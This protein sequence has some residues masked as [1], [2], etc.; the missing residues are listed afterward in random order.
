MKNHNQNQNRTDQNR[1]YL[2]GTFQ[3]HR[4]RLW[5]RYNDFGFR[6]EAPPRLLSNASCKAD[7]MDGSS[8]VFWRLDNI[9]SVCSRKTAKIRVSEEI[10]RFLFPD[11]NLFHQGRLIRHFDAWKTARSFGKNL[12]PFSRRRCSAHSSNL[13]SVWIWKRFD[14][15]HVWVK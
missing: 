7:A 9:C 11:R 4:F 12:F 10:A 5:K 15:F 2:R 13:Y 3:Q 8:C 14:K 6:R 1:I